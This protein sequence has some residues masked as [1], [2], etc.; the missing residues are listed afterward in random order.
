MIEF[1]QQ[2]INGLAQGGIYALIALGYTMVYGIIE[3]INFAHGDIFMMGAFVSLWTLSYWPLPA[4]LD[5]IGLG[6][7]NFL[8]PFLG[9]VP[10]S[11]A[12]ARTS[13]AARSG[14][15][16]RLVPIIHGLVLLAA[17]FGYLDL[18]VLSEAK[19]SLGYRLE[20][21]QATAAMIRDYPLSGCG[22][23]NFQAYYAK[24][25]LPQSSE[26]VADPHNFLFEIAATSGLP[27]LALWVFAWLAWFRQM[28]VGG[29]VAEPTSASAA[30]AAGIT[31]LDPSCW[32][33]RDL[34][35][36]ADASLRAEWDRTATVCWMLAEINRDRKKRPKPFEIDEFHPMTTEVERRKKRTA[37]VPQMSRL[38]FL[39]A[40]RADLERQGKPIPESLKRETE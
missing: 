12:V 11:A 29:A 35:E 16:T 23:G 2:L 4:P 28:T 19:K 18:Q 34:M 30:R 9:G 39:K 10:A 26:M 22:V 1:L 38:A 6:L 25:K 31:G 24:Y 20:Y 7:G 5:K 33:L 21:W 36:A 13:V 15:R 3:L 8:L 27:A 37:N 17:K 40:C 32:K 14:G